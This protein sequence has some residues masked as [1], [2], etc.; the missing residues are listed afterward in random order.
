MGLVKC[1]L[2]FARMFANVF[3]TS[4]VEYHCT[5]IVQALAHLGPQCMG[6]LHRVVLIVVDYNVYAFGEHVA[7]IVGAV[8]SDFRYVAGTNVAYKLPSLNLSGG[9]LPPLLVGAHFFVAEGN[10]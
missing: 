9:V 5:Q 7:I 3:P 6:R 8:L 2:F 10:M 4:F 1:L